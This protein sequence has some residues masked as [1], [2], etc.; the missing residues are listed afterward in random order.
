MK[1]AMVWGA[2]GGIGR[3]LVARLKDDGWTVLA[4]GRHTDRVAQLTPYR[5]EADVAD[6]RA[7][8]RA[9]V[10]V[11]QHSS[12][13]DLWIYA[14]GDIAA[15]KVNDATPEAWQQILG[16]NLVGAFLATRASLSVLAPDAHLVFLGAVSE[17]LRLPRLSAYASAKAGLEAFADVLSKEERKRRVTVVRPGAVATPLWE[18][19][20]FQVPPGAITPEELAAQILEAH[21]Q[22]HQGVLNL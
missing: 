17:R 22:G 12:A 8:E 5:F 1:T 19:V 21:K 20:P 14:V 3:A 7:V 11:G 6:P 10:E 4:M 16:A 13:V 9:M 2:G 18:K 15:T